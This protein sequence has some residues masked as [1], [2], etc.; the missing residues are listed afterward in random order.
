MS[1]AW[2]ITLRHRKTRGPRPRRARR[3]WLEALEDRIVFSFATGLDYPVGTHPQTVAVADLNGDG[4]PDL[5]VGNHFDDGTDGASLTILPGNADGTFQEQNAI[6]LDGGPHP[7][8]IAVGNFDGDG[9]L[10]LAVTND[11][12]SAVAGTV[13]VLY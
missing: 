13:T 12:S 2:W 5:I 11:S 7:S 9:H 1:R 4:H 10:D 3:P 6:T 8:G